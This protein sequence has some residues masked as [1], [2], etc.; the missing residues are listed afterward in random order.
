MQQAGFSDALPM[1]AASGLLTYGASQDMDNIINMLKSAGLC[2]QVL[3][4][5]LF[6]PKE[7]LDGAAA[8]Q[9][10]SSHTPAQQ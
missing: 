5:E 9:H 4:K 8:V 3:Y 10:P 6:I 7:E 2:S 1:Y